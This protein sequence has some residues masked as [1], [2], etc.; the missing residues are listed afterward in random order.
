M[1]KIDYGIDAPGVIRNLFIFSAIGFL[2]P[3]FYPQIRIGQ[4]NIYIG[5]FIW[6][7]ISCGLMAIWMLMYSLYGKLKHRDRILN[8]IEWKG[9]EIVLDVGTGRGLL[10]IG[11]AKRLTTGKSIGIDIWNMEDLTKNSMENTIDNAGL[12][13]VIDKVEVKND[14]ATNMSFEANTFD[15]VISNLCLHNIYDTV[16]RKKAC[17]EIARVLKKGGIGIISDFK[18]MKEYKKNFEELGLQT[19][20]I[21]TSYFTTFPPLAILIIKN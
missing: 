16:A 2:L 11:A 18:H 4:L 15:V 9:N 7:G 6:M 19:E 1:K 14:N 12:E 5:G 21:L 3:I 20:A 13:G 10:M 8:Q 17:S